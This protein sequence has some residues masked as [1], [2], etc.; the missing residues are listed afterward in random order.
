MNEREKSVT[1]QVPN[2]QACVVLAGSLAWSSFP[3]SPSLFLREWL[4]DRWFSMERSGRS[5]ARKRMDELH[6]GGECRDNAFL[7]HA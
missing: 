1:L 4:S 3:S 5:M 7:S 6:I 2:D